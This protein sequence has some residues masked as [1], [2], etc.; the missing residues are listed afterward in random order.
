MGREGGRVGGW[1]EGMDGGREGGRERSEWVVGGW[2][3]MVEGGVAE[4]E[5]ERK[6]GKGSL[7]P[8]CSNPLKR[9][10]RGRAAANVQVWYVLVSTFAVHLA[11]MALGTSPS[12][13]VALHG[14]WAL[15][16]GTAG[17]NAASH[18]VLAT[19][20]PTQYCGTARWHPCGRQRRDGPKGGGLSSAADA[21]WAFVALVGG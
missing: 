19:E 9:C 3:E 15:A 18:G 21:P 16:H 14:H 5:W 8:H 10:N 1:E 4:D 17:S 6:R 20:R 13:L 12:R 11:M 2:W 7:C